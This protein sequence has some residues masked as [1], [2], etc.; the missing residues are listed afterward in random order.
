MLIF[1]MIWGLCSSAPTVIYHRGLMDIFY[2]LMYIIYRFPRHYR[3]RQRGVRKVNK[4]LLET[5]DDPLLSFNK[6]LGLVSLVRTRY[7]FSLQH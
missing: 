3:G 7:S 1:I 6:A 2:M 5:L 4:I